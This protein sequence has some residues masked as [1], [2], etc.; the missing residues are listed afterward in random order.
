MVLTCITTNFNVSLLF[1]LIGFAFLWQ[2][3]IRG[4]RRP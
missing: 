1:L 3:I 4:I 2:D